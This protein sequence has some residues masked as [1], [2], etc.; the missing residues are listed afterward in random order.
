M[1]HSWSSGQALVLDDSYVHWVSNPSLDE[2][3]LDD[4]EPLPDLSDHVIAGN[5]EEQADDIFAAQLPAI[6]EERKSKDSDLQ[7]ID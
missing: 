6:E 2:D 4:S 1:L 7:M 3:L 5:E